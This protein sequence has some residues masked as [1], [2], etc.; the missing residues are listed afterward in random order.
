MAKVEDAVGD[1]AD[2]IGPFLDKDQ[3]QDDGSAPLDQDQ[4]DQLVNTALSLLQKINE[5]DRKKCP[6][7]P[8][9]G[10]LVGVVYGLLDM[11]TSQGILPSLSSGVTFRQRPRSVLKTYLLPS[12]RRKTSLLFHV[13][14]ELLLILKQTA[15]GVQPLLTQRV[16]PDLLSALAELAFS[17]QSV[18]EGRPFFQ[19]SY[20]DVLAKTPTSRLL[21]ILTSYLQQDLPPWLQ[22]RLSKE[23]AMVPLRP[24]GVRHTI[25]FVSLAYMS[26]TSQAPPDQ[27]S[28]P[29]QIPIPLEAITQASRLLASVPKEMTSDEWFTKLAPQLLALL[30]GT[31]GPELSRA[32]GQIIAGGILNK[33]STGAPGAIGWVLFAEQ[34]L[35]S[36][37]PNKE[38]D[39]TPR[40]GTF[41][42]VFVIEKDLKLALKRLSVI[43]SSYS[44]PG[45]IKRLVGPAML[46][47]WG[48][49]CYAGAHRSLDKTWTQLPRDILSRYIM[50]ACDPKQ[51]DLMATNIFWDGEDFWTFGPG[52]QGGVEI[53]Q[54]A[55]D[56]DSAAGVGSLLSRIEKLD[57]HV[58]TLATL[59]VDAK[60]DDDV[61]G[62]IFLNTTKRW[63]STGRIQS[64]NFLIDEGDGDPLAALVTA[65]LSEAMATIFKSQF[66]RSP[67][68]IIDLMRELLR[69]FVDEHQSKSQGK[70]NT[71][72]PKSEE[73]AAFA[74]SI[75]NT[76]V[77]APDYKQ[78]SS[79]TDSLSTVLPSLKYLSQPQ[80][81]RPVSSLISNAASNLLQ[82][83]Q[84]AYRPQEDREAEYRAKLQQAVTDLTSPDPP[85]R[86]WALS[87]LRK[88]INDPKAFPFIDIPSTTHM[89]LSASIADYE[90]YVHTA[91]VNV[92]VD[93]TVRAPTPTLGILT[94][95]FTDVD[96]RS[97]RLRKENEIKE[98]LDFRLRVGEVLNNFVMEDGY[99]IR[100]PD[101]STRF[102][103]IKLLTEAILSVA[104]RRGQRSKTLSK[105][106]QLLDLERK[107]QEEG[108]RA[109]GGPIPNLL[110]DEGETA[111]EQGERQ[112]LL[113]IVQ[114][115]EDTGIEED[116]RARASALS[117]LG[118]V[119]EQR[120]EL[121][122][123][124]TVDGALQMALTILVLETGAEKGILRRAAVLV[125]MG[126]LRSMDAWLEDGKEG[127]VG[128]GMKQSEEVER[129]M[130]WVADGDGDD[131]VKS[132]AENVLEGL[133]TW[134][135]KKLFKLRDEGFKLGPNLGLEGNL[136]GLEVTPLADE[137]KTLLRRPVVEELE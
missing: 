73:L 81:Q 35:R 4:N 1:A 76:L 78:D 99:W 115:W 118:S 16:L 125:V 38:L 85:N 64:K 33:R 17:P 27:S 26:K 123:Q 70:G 117:I 107:E 126:L 83:L 8:Y 29:S 11:I 93:L 133:E 112:H 39:P 94:G 135:M 130:R 111:A 25:E 87:T 72:K 45:L 56:H 92:L 108:E 100:G 97:L 80:Q 5:E 89:I 132:H 105:R 137:T 119:M 37:N 31:D 60:I 59:L 88:L 63:L 62:T 122:S 40:T 96:E 53:R 90:S 121:L 6:D 46:S 23:L 103:S 24:H 69:N 9:D 14:Q 131:L 109:W 104:S 65:K 55:V 2:F 77:T 95:A 47:L 19:A 61:A 101:P 134:R 57:G 82:I 32:A 43:V 114:G 50:I 113:K 20:G 67:R 98:A 74:L 136:R 30:D 22:S 13:V 75:L 52:S 68:H 66:A 48:L 10:S 7:A 3:G 120:V 54:R 84:P 36:L 51:I 79:S 42:R 28:S 12:P 34:L 110:D 129:V 44:H 106:T 21:P 18:T 41:D 116:V 127:A 102:T 58:N 124:I 49:V 15:E 71:L 91:A 128:L 86:T